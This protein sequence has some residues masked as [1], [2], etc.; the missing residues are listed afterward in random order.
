MCGGLEVC[1]F[2]VVLVVHACSLFDSACVVVCWF[3]GVGV[4]DV[5][6][7]VTFTCGGGCVLFVVIVFAGCL[8]CCCA[9]C[10]VLLL[11]YICF[12]IAGGCC[13]VFA[14]YLLPC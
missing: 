4:V 13:I 5:G 10:I 8:F 1:C 6:V 14:C 2:E 11:F 7:V 12:R 3:V 9:V